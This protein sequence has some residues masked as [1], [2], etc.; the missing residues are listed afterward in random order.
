[1][2][3]D[4]AFCRFAHFD[5]ENNLS[6][7][8]SKIR[9]LQDLHTN[10]VFETNHADYILINPGLFNRRVFERIGGFLPGRIGGDDDLPY[11]AV[12]SGQ[13]ICFIEEALILKIDQ[14]DSITADPSG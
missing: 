12:L 9:L 2:N 11:R 10:V 5:L 8:G 3:S 13:R 6:V 14:T 4:I 7:R 1:M